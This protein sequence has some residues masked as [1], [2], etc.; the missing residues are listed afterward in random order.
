MGLSL[1]LV[2]E[3][4]TSSSSILLV[5]SDDWLMRASEAVSFPGGWGLMIFMVFLGLSDSALAQTLVLDQGRPDN[6][7]LNLATCLVVLK[8]VPS[9]WARM[10][11][12]SRS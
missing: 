2:T 10:S 4:S 3:M 5:T 8:F 12:T 9:V 6:K 11:A 1:V 7:L